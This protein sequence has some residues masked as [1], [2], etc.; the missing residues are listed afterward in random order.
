MLPWTRKKLL[1]TLDKAKA[2]LAKLEAI[3]SER[4]KKS[5]S[6][7]KMPGVETSFIFKEILHVFNC[8]RDMDRLMETTF[9]EEKLFDGHLADIRKSLRK[10]KRDKIATRVLH[11]LEGN[12]T[13][14]MA[15]GD[16]VM[17]GD[18]TATNDA[19]AAPNDATTATNNAAAALN[20]AASSENNNAAASL[21]KAPSS[22]REASPETTEV[23]NLCAQVCCLLSARMAEAQEEISKRVT[24][25]KSQLQEDEK[26]VL[27]EFIQEVHD[28][29]EKEE[30]STKEDSTSNISVADMEDGPASETTTS[31]SSGSS[32][33][34]PSVESFL[35]LSHAPDH[36]KFFS[37]PTAPTD[38]KAFST[39]VRRVPRSC[40]TC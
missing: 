2:A 24:Q 1:D 4:A 23:C 10:I 34:Q 28:E 13:K 7:P 5:S 22:E 16:V 12:C 20:G 30:A 31:P 19:A 37:K 35:A 26:K 3:F 11:R 14:E 25:K 38:Q 9:F 17:N 6:N 21:E 27:D 18:A 33:S 39:A 32:P 40:R 15:N 36:H 8:C 29:L